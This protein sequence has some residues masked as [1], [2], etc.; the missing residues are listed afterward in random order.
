[1][2]RM[3]VA[4][5]SREPDV[6]AFFLDCRHVAFGLYPV[7]V[8][9]SREKRIETRRPGLGH[10]AR[11]D[12]ANMAIRKGWSKIAWKC[13]SRHLHQISR[14]KTRFG[15]TLVPQ[16][17]GARPVLNEHTSALAEGHDGLELHGRQTRSFTWRQ[18]VNLAYVGEYTVRGGRIGTGGQ[19][20][21]QFG[22]ARDRKS[23]RLNSSHL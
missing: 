20:P 5:R 13:S 4:F 3:Y 10:H 17:D 19:G 7:A 18:G 23:T 9:A 14:S 6:T 12:S 8:F 22:G 21:L 16:K 2:P 15:G 11:S 1:M